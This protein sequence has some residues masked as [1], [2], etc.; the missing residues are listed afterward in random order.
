MEM[1]EQIQKRIHERRAFINKDDNIE[2]KRFQALK[3]EFD[4]HMENGYYTG[5][6]KQI[7]WT[8]LRHNIPA[9][10]MAQL[11]NLGATN[12]KTIIH[13]IEPGDK[14]DGS[15]AFKVENL[16]PFCYIFG[17]DIQALATIAIKTSQ[18]DE[19][20]MDAANIIYSLDEDV[21]AMILE[22]IR[23]KKRIRKNSPIY[24]KEEEVFE[25]IK[26]EVLLKNL[27]PFILKKMVI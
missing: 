14:Y 5:I 7:E 13:R 10:Q 9:T 23:N 11:L 4:S 27:S 24:K 2:L 19:V 22:N 12:Y 1:N 18:A 17:Y 3:K 21:L 15:A 6:L 16:L 20:C 25:R 26:T 8:R